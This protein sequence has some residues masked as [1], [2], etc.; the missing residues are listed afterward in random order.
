MRYRLIAADM[1]GTLLNDYGEVSTAVRIAIDSAKALGLNFT[2]STGRP[3]L[4]VEPYLD[5]IDG[6]M[7]VITCNGALIVTAR[8]RRII[9]KTEIS[10]GAANIIIE[11]GIKEGALVAAWAEEKLF[12]SELQSSYSSFYKSLTGMEPAHISQLPD[13]DVTKIVYIMPPDR[14]KYIQRRFSPPT[15]VQTKASDSMFLEFFSD[16]AGKGRALRILA[17]YFGIDISETLAIGDNYNDLEMLRTAGLG[18]AMENAPEDI[19]KSAD[20][21]TASNNDDG[22]ALAIQKFILNVR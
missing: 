14:I 1:D 10:R 4:G 7:P 16:I 19:K 9:S 21:V 18:I 2:V 3:M 5:L 8:T 11:R 12:S 22:V 17:E 20:F 15:G 6:D 13:F